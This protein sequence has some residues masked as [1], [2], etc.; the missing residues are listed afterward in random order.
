MVT[1]I[2][3]ATLRDLVN[4]Y[5]PPYAHRTHHAHAAPRAGRCVVP[6]AASCR[7]LHRAGHRLAA[8]WARAARR[9][10][11]VRPALGAAGFRARLI[12]ASPKRSPAQPAVSLG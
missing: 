5:R 4:V 11:A 3:R 7:A 8:R 9:F 6:C 10:A 1:P 2:G 12:S